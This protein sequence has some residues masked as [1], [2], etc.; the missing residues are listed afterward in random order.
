MVLTLDPPAYAK[1]RFQTQKGPK[2]DTK[3]TKSRIKS[4]SRTFLA[5]FW[6]VTDSWLE[7]EKSVQKSPKLSKSPLFDILV[8][9]GQTFKTNATFPTESDQ[10]LEK[11]SKTLQNPPK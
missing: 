6:K 7:F 2:I 8:G 5:G 4:P 3:M 1:Q 10:T 11:S 9:P